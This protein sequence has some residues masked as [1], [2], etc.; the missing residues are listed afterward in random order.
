MTRAGEE[1]LADRILH[2][3]RS[4]GAYRRLHAEELDELERRLLELKDEVLVSRRSQNVKT[5]TDWQG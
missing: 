4:L 3:E 1:P 2:L 5:E